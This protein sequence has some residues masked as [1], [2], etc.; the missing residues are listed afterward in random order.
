MSIGTALRVA[1]AKHSGRPLRENE[2]AL[3][4][5]MNEQSAC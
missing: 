3:A 2:A 5:P 4:Q 1:W